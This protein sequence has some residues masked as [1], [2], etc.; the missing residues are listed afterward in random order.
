MGCSFH[1]RYV[2]EGGDDEWEFISDRGIR[3]PYNSQL[4]QFNTG[5][6]EVLYS[7]LELAHIIKE[8]VVSLLADS[9]NTEWSDAI[10]ALS[11]VLQEMNTYGYENVELGYS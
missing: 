2:K 10:H 1:F 9:S 3:L 11:M 5:S 7:V 6:D 8:F 4:T